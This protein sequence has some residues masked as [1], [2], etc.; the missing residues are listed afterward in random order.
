MKTRIYATPAVKGL[1]IYV[2]HTG[3]SSIT[4]GC[5]L[6]ICSVMISPVFLLLLH[7]VVVVVELGIHSVCYVI[8]SE[9]DMKNKLSP[10]TTQKSD[11]GIIIRFLTS[12]NYRYKKYN[13]VALL[14]SI[15]IK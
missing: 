1:M 11:I 3:P 5:S 8:T 15:G 6:C 14:I 9:P 12:N 4:E 13:Q 2:F 10:E 7:M